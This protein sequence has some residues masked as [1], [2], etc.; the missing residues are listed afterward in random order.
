MLSII[1]NIKVKILCQSVT[2]HLLLGTQR[3]VKFVV[4][5]QS[6][7]MYLN[8]IQEM[9]KSYPTRHSLCEYYQSRFVK[10]ENVDSFTITLSCNTIK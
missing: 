8:R 2:L 10:C 7:K 5:D 6:I 1:K 3:F 9:L 4:N